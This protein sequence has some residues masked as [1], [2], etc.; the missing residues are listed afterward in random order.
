VGTG[1]TSGH[2]ANIMSPLRSLQRHKNSWLKAQFIVA[3]SCVRAQVQAALSVCL[4]VTSQYHAK[5]NP[6]R[7]TGFS[8]PGRPGTVVFFDTNFN[9]RDYVASSNTG[10]DKNGD[11]RPINHI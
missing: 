9:T 4:S 5:T 2:G 1:H 10:M 3:L 11:F 6:Y 8:P 7:I